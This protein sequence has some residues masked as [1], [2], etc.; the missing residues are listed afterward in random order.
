MGTQIRVRTI[1]DGED[2]ESGVDVPRKISDRAFVKGE[3]VS[4]GTA[5]RSKW[6]GV[7]AS[8]ELGELLICADTWIPE[9]VSSVI[10][11]TSASI[12]VERIRVVVAHIKAIVHQTR[13]NGKRSHLGRSS[14]V[15]AR[16]NVDVDLT[17][18]NKTSTV[19]NTPSIGVDAWSNNA[20]EASRDTWAVHETR[21]TAVNRV[22]SDSY[23][24]SCWTG[25]GC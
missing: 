23:R 2:L 12:K 11:T 17:V 10:Y 18:L 6:I 20:F 4:H 7:P 19:I 22:S 5:F 3:R 24:A 14:Q 1:T 13:G 21:R 8:C 25:S 16:T 15:T 9:L